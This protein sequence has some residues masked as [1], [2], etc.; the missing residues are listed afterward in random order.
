M[1]VCTHTHTH[2]R[3]TKL[4]EGG[5]QRTTEGIQLDR[6]FTKHEKQKQ[7]KK[8]GNLK[9]NAHESIKN[10]SMYIPKIK[11]YIL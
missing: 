3:I 10:I 2:T 6:K 5:W 8:P 9:R 4:P 7:N 1:Y 11:R